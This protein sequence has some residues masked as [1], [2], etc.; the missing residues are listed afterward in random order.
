LEYRERTLVCAE[1]RQS[2]A[3]SAAEQLFYADHAL[4]H[5]PRR[6]KAC[7][8]RALTP[9]VPSRRRRRERVEIAA[10]CACC[11]RETTVPFRPSQGRPVYCRDC[12][13]KSR[14]ARKAGD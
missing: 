6:C 13:A 3:W 4:R 5:E 9:A 11:G 10:R 1:C 14:E 8:Q 7:R 12:F 2:F